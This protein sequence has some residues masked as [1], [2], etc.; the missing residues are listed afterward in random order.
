MLVGVLFTSLLT[1]MLLM[2]ISFVY[3]ANFVFCG[4]FVCGCGMFDLCLQVAA[5]FWDVLYC[6]SFTCSLFVIVRAGFGF[7]AG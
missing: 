4:L 7:D 5:L 3:L 1:L 6:T 2:L